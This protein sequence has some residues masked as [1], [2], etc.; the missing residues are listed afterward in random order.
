MVLLLLQSKVTLVKLTTKK[1]F[2]ASTGF[3]GGLATSIAIL[4]HELP[5]EIGDFAVLL[6]AGLSARN[7]V[8]YNI[9]SSVLAFVGMA[10]GLY[11]G[12]LGGGALSAYIAGTFLHISLVDMMPQLSSLEPGDADV[13]D[14]RPR[15]LGDDTAQIVQS[16][17]KGR[18]RSRAAKR[19]ANRAAGGILLLQVTGIAAGI[20]IMYLVASFE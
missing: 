5:H 7:A 12:E 17:K 18:R 14:E 19:A 15:D 3:Y 20:V 11:I 2:S 1:T 9:L 16:H 13:D 6:K 10:L 4:M 8:K